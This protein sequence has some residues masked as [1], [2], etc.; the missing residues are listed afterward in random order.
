MRFNDCVDCNQP[1]GQY[2]VRCDE[3]Y[4]K[5]IKRLR[6]E[7]QQTKESRGSPNA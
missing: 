2:Q 6:E 5:E 7:L 3:C 1:I 4:E